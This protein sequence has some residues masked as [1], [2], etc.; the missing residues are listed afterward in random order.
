MNILDNLKIKIESKQKL[1]KNT[2]N[3]KLLDIYSSLESITDIINLKKNKDRFNFI[4]DEKFLKLY[5][6]IPSLEEL[7]MIIGKKNVK[8]TIFKKYLLFYSWYK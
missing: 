1:E 3:K 2:K 4:D 8:E 5:N 7:D 6:L